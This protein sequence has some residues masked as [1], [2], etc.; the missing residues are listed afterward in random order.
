MLALILR[1]RLE[2]VKHSTAGPVLKEELGLP[3]DA[4]VYAEVGNPSELSTD[5]NTFQFRATLHIRHAV[6]SRA[7]VRNIPSQVYGQGLS[8]I[9]LP[10]DRQ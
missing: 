3:L 5:N 7:S 8:S 1:R 2:L 4:G 9:H 10:R 6:V